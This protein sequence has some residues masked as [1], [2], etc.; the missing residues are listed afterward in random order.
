MP[1][2]SEAPVL[3]STP[4]TWFA[5]ASQPCLIVPASIAAL[6][7]AMNSG[8]ST[9]SAWMADQPPRTAIAGTDTTE[10]TCSA[11]MPK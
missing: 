5:R 4:G 3:A 10:M 11:R 7:E 1:I 8:E 2:A 9:K 6:C